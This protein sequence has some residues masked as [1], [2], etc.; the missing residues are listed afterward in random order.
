VRDSGANRSVSASPSRS[1]RELHVDQREPEG[2]WLPAA[3]S[4]FCLA[5]L[6][7][8]TL[9]RSEPIWDSVTYVRMA[10]GHLLAGGRAPLCF[11]VLTPAIASVLPLPL[12]AAFELLNQ[13][14]LWCA[15]IAVYYLLRARGLSRDVALA[16]SALLILSAFSKF[17][18]WYRFGVDQVAILGICAVVW[19]TAERRFV[20]AAGLATVAAFGKESI[21]LLAPFTYGELRSST[22]F[23]NRPTS[24]FVATVLL[25]LGALVVVVILRSMIPQRSGGGVLATIHRWAGLRL[26]SPK[27]Y[28]EMVLALPK[29]FG[30]IPLV[31]VILWRRTWL[32]LRAEAYA[33]VTIA[34]FVLAGIF[35]A[36][37]YER[38]YFLAFPLV[39]IV[40]ARL[41]AG[42]HPTLAQV[43]VFVLAQVS[44]LDVF[45]RPDFMDLP[46]WFMVN[47]AW[48][49]LAYF[50]S[51]V[52]LWTIA[53][54]AVSRP[55]AVPPG[56]QVPSAA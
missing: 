13:V 10:S 49:D 32:A 22:R 23:S 43:A 36:S 4:A 8:F 40:C 46:R 7:L 26:A 9:E 5:L 30:A 54:W 16:G 29:T 53:L 17:V 50:G 3:F 34:V 12:P 39:G 44:L 51:K 56:T 18:V 55:S 47:T 27:A 6:G 48:S 41:I 38:V 24:R 25:W 1:A 11:R 52:L 31:L 28:V 19:A 45:A 42:A 37:D 14:S 15:G 35:G 2:I 21:I 20:L 33:S